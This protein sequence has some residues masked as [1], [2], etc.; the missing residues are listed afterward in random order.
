MITISSYQEFE[1][2]IIAQKDDEDYSEAGFVAVVRGD[3]AAL[4]AYSHCS[5]NGTWEALNDHGKINWDWSGTPD[6]LVAMAEF[7]GDPSF[8]GR[9]AV[10]T[11]Y[12]FR[13]LDDVYRQIIEWDKS[14][15]PC[16]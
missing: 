12:D 14:G 4:S 8:P 6:Q 7:G 9:K 5:C 1:K 3:E 13:W 10:F 11:D 16:R 15:R 2:Y